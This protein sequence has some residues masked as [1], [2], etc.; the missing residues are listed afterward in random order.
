[1][2][3]R[4]GTIPPVRVWTREEMYGTFDPDAIPDLRAGNALNYR[5]SW[6]TSLGGVPANVL[7]DN[8]KPWSGDHCSSDPS[9]VRGILFSSRKINRTDP[10]MIDIAPSVLKALGVP[11]PEAM[12]GKPLY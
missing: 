9:L 8:L 10:A 7:E 1:M 5:V 12:D 6:Q 4:A 11:V 3:Q 2:Q